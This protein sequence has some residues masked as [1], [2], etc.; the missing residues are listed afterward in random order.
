VKDTRTTTPSIAHAAFRVLFG[1]VWG[2]DAALKWL[3]GFRDSF[4]AMLQA[5]AKGQ[6][7]WLAPWFNLWSGLNHGETTLLAYGTA[8][9]ET[10]LAIAVILGFARKSTYLIGAVY[11]LLVWATAEGFGG[12]YQSGATDIGTAIIYA[13]V[14]AGLLV[15]AASA[16]SDRR[17]SLDYYLESRFGWWQRIAEVGWRRKRI[18]PSANGARVGHIPGPVSVPDRVG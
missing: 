9:M 16:D 13:F 8:L 6:P 11:S 3:P 17:Y 14:F 5:A 18:D 7:G 2:I 1:L 12:P 15:L 4:Q 10:F